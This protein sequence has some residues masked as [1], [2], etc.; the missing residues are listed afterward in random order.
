MVPL[1]AAVPKV[2]NEA[3]A[4][5]AV[6]VTLDVETVHPELEVSEDRKRVRWTRAQ[7]DLPDTG[8]GFIQ[9]LCVQ[10]HLETESVLKKEV[11][12]VIMA[13]REQDWDWSEETICA[14]CLDF[15]T[16]PISLECGHNFCLS[17]ISQSQERKIY[18]CPECRATFPD[19]NLKVNRALANLAEKARR[20]SLNSKEDERK[21]HC[22]EHEEELKLFCESD[23]KLICVICSTAR[24]HREHR[25]MPVKEAVEIHKA[26][27]KISLELLMEKN[28]V[29]SKTEKQQKQ[30][31]NEIRE[32][33]RRLQNHVTSEFTKM[34][35]FLTEKEQQYIKNLREQEQR[36]LETMERNLQEIQVNLSA[37]REK[38]S[39]LKKQMEQKN[40]VVFL[41]EQTC[42]MN[43]ISD[44]YNLLQVA[45]G[46]LSIE[47]FDKPFFVIWREMFE[48]INPVSLTLDVETANKLLEVSD[49][50]KSVRWTRK[51]KRLSD[52]GKRFTVW[53]CVLGSEGFM[54][55]IHYWEVEVAGNGGWS[56]GVATESVERKRKVDL[57][58]ENGF[59]T[60][61]RAGDRFNA[62]SSPPSPLPANSMPSK[63]GVYLSYE[64]GTVSFYNAD[65]KSHLHTFSGNEFM[66]K[67]YPFFWTLD[68]KTALRV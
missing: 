58:P 9:R 31:I 35:Q 48:A 14:I 3:N 1:R 44:E 25:F 57:T 30:K 6:S 22:E 51:Q 21:L 63:V 13:S 36:I 45:D 11:L 8:K 50:L 67:L 46:T 61:R 16:E 39:K 24:E 2:T 29:V 42:Q 12:D 27:V 40:S 34:H 60:I 68:E 7:R 10:K 66:E 53:P 26:Q 32:Q 47:K 20:L 43:R 18:S 23:K 28:S 15:F 4:G 33:S 41:Q 65:T 55:G 62:N 59:W 49:D 52:T 37:I 56:V 64:S 17:C 54:S 19:R 38:L 5:A